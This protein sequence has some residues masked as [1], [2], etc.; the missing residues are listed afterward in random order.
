MLF[1]R[2][3]KVAKL[4]SLLIVCSL[5]S[6]CPSV[7]ANIRTEGLQKGVCYATWTKDS[8]STKYSD[9]SLSRMAEIGVE[10]VSIVVT[11]YQ[12]KYNSTEIRPT[13]LSPSDS[14]VRHVIKRAHKLGLKVML[15][16]HIDLID[17]YDGTYWRADIGFSN[18]N[19]WEEWFSEYTKFILHYAKMADD[20]GVEIL[21]IGTE[22]TFTT[23]KDDLWRGVISE[24]KSEYSGQLVYAA[25]WDNYRNIKFWD[26]LDYVGIDAYFP[27][28]NK[29]DPSMDELKEG[30]LKWKDEIETWLVDINKPVIFTEIGYPSTSHAP[31]TPWKSG[32]YGNANLEIQAKCYESFFETIWGSPWLAGVYWWKWGTNIYSGGKHNRQ[33]TP[34][35]KPAEKILEA[36]YK[37]YMNTA[38]Y[39]MLT[40]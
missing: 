25:N 13:D 12:E 33:F 22:L 23:I 21:C 32:S 2:I 27:L 1:Q 37:D 19:A 15:K 16:P 20:Y 11:Y 7:Y 24:V 9:E 34:Q 18:Q 8:F 35:N 6:T 31:Y 36:R 28:T 40:N 30:W 5:L 38:T 17:Q 3:K 29:P 39:A 14:S 26:A 10:Y 4:T